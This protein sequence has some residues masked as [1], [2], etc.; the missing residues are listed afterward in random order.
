MRASASSTAGLLGTPNASTH[1]SVDDGQRRCNVFVRSILGPILFASALLL[2]LVFYAQIFPA[3]WGSAQLS[4]S[5]E[6]GIMALYP[7]TAAAI[8]AMISHSS[9]GLDPNVLITN[10]CT[11]YTAYPSV[12]AKE[13]SIFHIPQ[14]ANL[15]EV[16]V[17]A[18]QAA[19]RH[20]NDALCLAIDCSGQE[21]LSLL[22]EQCTSD[23]IE[24]LLGV[25]DQ[26]N[27]VAARL[28]SLQGLTNGAALRQALVD[29][30]VWLS[31]SVSYQTACSDNFEAAPGSIQ[32]Q[33]QTN[34]AYLTQVLDVALALVDALSQA[35]FSDITEN[36]TVAKDGSGNYTTVTAAVDAIPSSFAG[37]Y[38]I[39]I[40]EGV[41]N[42]VLNVT[43][44]KKNVTFFGDGVGKTIITGDRNVA[45]GDYNTFRTPTVG[46]AGNGF[47]ACDL[48]F[49]NTAG[50]SGHQAVALRAAA[51]YAVFFRCS[52]EGY[53]DTL[54]ALSSRQF[55][56]DCQISGTV[57]YIFGNAI[58]VFQ[59]CELV[60]R[61]PMKGQQNAYTAQGRQL[62]ANV[63]GYSFHN[64]TVKADAN[65]T[66]AYFT[67]RTSLGRPWKEYSRT[68]FIQSELQAVVQP[69]GWL[70]WNAS[71][72]YTDT[73]YYGKYGNRGD[74]ADTSQ[75]VAWKGVH[76][77]MSETD[78]SQFTVANF[79]G[80]QSWLEALFVP[81][82]AD[83]I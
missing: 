16:V 22:E 50:P 24:L 83:L 77:N 31:T 63:S 48:T 39:Y 55:Y 46:I 80:L 19:E 41:Y 52:F 69:A 33:I 11:Q 43:K 56:R 28:S 10:I 9:G 45:S 59:N 42:E 2:S 58:A 32:H 62:E 26:M 18:T 38:V 64:C 37:R 60:A 47:F 25:M 76:P 27:L 74:G 14:T 67:V 29:V 35:P 79:I 30:K 15:L 13:F 81:Y 51:D 23:C 49:R 72:P 36:A 71:N 73:V 21:R 53:Q 54:Y 61:L 68:V 5:S 12:C 44:D 82:Q 70:P 17:F 34:Q 3:S 8:S 7:D 57:D 78:A 1:A 65:L 40:K 66:D 20:I 4:S 6:G 75:R